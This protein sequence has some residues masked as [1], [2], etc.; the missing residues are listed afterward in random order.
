MMQFPEDVIGTVILSECT[1]GTSLWGTGVG[2]WGGEG[3]REREKEILN[4]NHKRQVSS[5]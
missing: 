1:L 4:V 2:G 3:A 5:C